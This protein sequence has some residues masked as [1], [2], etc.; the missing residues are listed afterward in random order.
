MPTPAVLREKRRFSWP[1]A[2][3]IIVAMMIVYSALPWLQD[4]ATDQ[5]DGKSTAGSPMLRTSIVLPS[6]APL[7]LASEIPGLGYNSPAIAISPDSTSLAY[8][9]RSAS[10]RVLYVRDMSTGEVRLLPGTE[11]AIRPFFS[12]D[13]QWIGFLTTDHVKKVPRRGG[14]VIVLCEADTPVHAWWRQQ[15]DGDC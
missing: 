10:A 3:V 8:V 1:L 14:T 2:V 4:D 9:G 7:A 15:P 11:D 12:P 6:D 13:G 5:S